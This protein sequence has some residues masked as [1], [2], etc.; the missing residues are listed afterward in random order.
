MQFICQKRVRIQLLLS[1]NYSHFTCAFNTILLLLPFLKIIQV[2]F[3][4]ENLNAI[5]SRK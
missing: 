2:I 1:L 5:K 3:I 4:A